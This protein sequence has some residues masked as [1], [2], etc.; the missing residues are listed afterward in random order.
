MCGSCRRRGAQLGFAT[1]RALPVTSFRT[2]T[3][4]FSLFSP[5]APETSKLS[6]MKVNKCWF[7]F[8]LLFRSRF[9][10]FDFFSYPN[11]ESW[12]PKGLVILH[13]P[14]LQAAPKCGRSRGQT[15]RGQGPLAW[16]HQQQRLYPESHLFPLSS[17]LPSPSL[18]LAPEGHTTVNIRDDCLVG[19]R[20]AGRSGEGHL[21]FG[22]G[23]I[24]SRR[25]GPGQTKG[26][27][28]TKSP[29]LPSPRSF[30]S[31]RP[32]PDAAPSPLRS[33]PA[34]AQGGPGDRS[35]VPR[36]SSSPGPPCHPLQDLRPP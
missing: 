1:H 17:L 16:G 2:R 14:K 18:T 33:P 31:R 7:P 9:P 20:N 15:R 28:R 30:P 22:S 36:R 8:S 25:T 26:P 29:P 11:Q 12:A 6:Y 13:F 21:P 27:G 10:G 24:L 32:R 5:Y 3:G 34:F 23:Y 35:S 19:G 4:L